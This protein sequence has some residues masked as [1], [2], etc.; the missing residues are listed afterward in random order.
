LTNLHPNGG[1]LVIAT[2]MEVDKKAT[3]DLSAVLSART[4]TTK[5]LAMSETLRE[6]SAIMMFSYRYPMATMLH[7]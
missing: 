5:M 3:A 2:A 4:A 6:G 1:S 7:S